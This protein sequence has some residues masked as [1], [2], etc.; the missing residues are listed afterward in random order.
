VCVRTLW[1]KGINKFCTAYLSGNGPDRTNS[2]STVKSE[3]FINSLHVLPVAKV[4][5]LK[6]T[7]HTI[8]L[9]LKLSLSVRQLIEW[10]PSE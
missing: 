1:A 6:V 4:N 7:L 9:S 5:I 10:Q 3:Q 8:S 2:H